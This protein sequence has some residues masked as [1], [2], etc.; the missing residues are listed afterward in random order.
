MN[1]PPE[2]EGEVKRRLQAEEIQGQCVFLEYAK[3]HLRRL[4][5]QLE[6]KEAGMFRRSEPSQVTEEEAANRK[7]LPKPGRREKMKAIPS[8]LRAKNS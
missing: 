8:E 6:I 2:A 4:E 7:R 5:Q 3:L 1:I